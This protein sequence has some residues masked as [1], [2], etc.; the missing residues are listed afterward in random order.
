MYFSPNG[1][2]L[3]E[4]SAGCWSLHYALL[5]SYEYIVQ[6]YMGSHKTYLN[7]NS[8]NNIKY[9]LQ[10]KYLLNVDAQKLHSYRKLW[11]ICILCTILTL[12]NTSVSCYNFKL[13]TFTSP[14]P[15]YHPIPSTYSLRCFIRLICV[16]S[17]VSHPSNPIPSTYSLRCG[18]HLRR[19]FFN[20][21]LG[22]SWGHLRDTLGTPWKQWSL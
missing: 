19:R 4:S 2:F 7:E 5:T 12:C 13:F 17:S 15:G 6:S 3:G 14:S 22:T 9:L 10:K 11:K 18:I 16:I 1:L 8:Q 21:P 20:D